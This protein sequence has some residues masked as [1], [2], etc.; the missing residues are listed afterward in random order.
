VPAGTDVDL[1]LDA[2]FGAV[3]YR[4]LFRHT[5][6]DRADLARLVDG[7]LDGFVPFS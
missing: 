5:D 2:Y 4:V 6:T 3:F 1:L 7:V